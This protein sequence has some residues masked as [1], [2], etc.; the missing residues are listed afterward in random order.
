MI[1]VAQD[2]WSHAAGTLSFIYC[3]N[4]YN[5]GRRRQCGRALSAEVR[6]VDVENEGDI[7]RELGG[8]SG[9]TCQELCAT[10]EYAY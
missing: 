1:V 6:K 8:E 7:K 5:H 3:A 9:E 10:I 4:N 2:R